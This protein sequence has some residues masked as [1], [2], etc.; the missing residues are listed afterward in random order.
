MADRWNDDVERDWRD[1]GR[2]Y[3]RSAG[4]GDHVR[5]QGGFDGEGRS[6]SP[7]REYE[8][9]RGG[10]RSEGQDF[11]GPRYAVGGYTG[12]GDRQFGE[13]GYGE[14]NYSTG[15]EAGEADRYGPSA[16]RYG[17]GRGGRYYGDD[18]R[19]ALYREEYGEGRPDYGAHRYDQAF[20]DRREGHSEF[21][22]G[23]D[24]DGADGRYRREAERD[25]DHGFWGTRGRRM[26]GLGEGV[27]RGRGPQGYKRSDARINEDVHER[28]TEDPH[29]D[30]SAV[31]VTVRDAEVTLSGMVDSREA[32]HHAEHLVE[33]LSG[34]AHVQ[35]NLRVDHHQR[36]SSQGAHTTAATPLGENTK[37][38]DQAAGKA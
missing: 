7:R 23:Y 14:R 19:R 20:Q 21:G 8:R 25:R 6:F 13:R 2:R 3:G 37:L 38:S 12:Y 32:K 15:Y 29:L 24:L 35:N 11:T 10:W 34:V 31:V 36:A 28:L 22:L 33:H 30:A 1:E 9:D 18:G 16:T 17:Q 27:H 4:E 5:G 26:F